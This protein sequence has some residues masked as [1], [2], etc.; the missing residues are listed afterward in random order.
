MGMR[1]R[2]MMNYLS[3]TE[4]AEISEGIQSIFDLAGDASRSKGILGSNPACGGIGTKI[5]SSL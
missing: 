4:Y 1:E 2:K 5:S 3:L